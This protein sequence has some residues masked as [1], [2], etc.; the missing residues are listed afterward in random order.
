MITL[1]GV[2]IIPTIFPD[3]T[4]QVWK[5]DRELLDAFVAIIQW[6]FESESELMHLAQLKM[7]L[8]VEII[9]SNLVIPYLPYGRQDKSVSNDRCYALQPFLR[10]L[11]SLK[12]HSISIFDPHSTGFIVKMQTIICTVWPF[13]E[14][15]TAIDA[16]NPDLLCFPDS[17]ARRKY[18]PMFSE[19][20]WIAFDK[21]RA[22]S[23]G[24]IEGSTFLLGSDNPQGKKILIVDDIC[25]GGATFIK[26]AE[27][28]Y[29]DKA[30][31]VNLYISHGLFTKGKQVLRDAG[32][33]RIFTKDGEQE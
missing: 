16:C 18:Q 21:V 26:T 19:Y 4:S 31:E 28:L 2:K 9:A 5:L 17:G 29:A 1:N 24:I 11:D 3:G 30:I 23:T 14:V 22:S 8:D 27:M 33:N 20:P 15:Q 13:T 6:D 7:L 12:F 10:I 25:D 32:I